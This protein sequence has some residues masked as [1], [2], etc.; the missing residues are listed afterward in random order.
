MKRP[1]VCPVPDEQQP[2]NEYQELNESAFFRSCGASLGQYLKTLAWRGVP[3]FLI[4]LPVSAASFR[5]EKYPV[6]FVLAALAGVIV[7][8]ALTVVRLY[9][10]WKHVRDRLEDETVIYEESGWY[11]GQTWTKTPEIQTR[12]QLIVAYQIQPIMQRLRRTFYALAIATVS[13]AT[14]WVVL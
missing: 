6:E 3:S 8:L 7:T 14:L 5:P 1:S 12:D 9:L 11:D 4:A 13:S 10:G 2:L